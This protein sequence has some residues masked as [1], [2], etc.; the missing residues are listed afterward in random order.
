MSCPAF[1]IHETHG[2]DY[3]PPRQVAVELAK[4]YP[5]LIVG[6][7]HRIGR[8]PEASPQPIGLRVIPEVSPLE[9]PRRWGLRMLTDPANTR[10][11]RNAVRAEIGHKADLAV[12]FDRPVQHHRVGA[13]REVASAYYAHCDYTVDILGRSDPS[14]QADELAMLRKVDVAFAAS[15][16]LVERFSRH[17][18]RVV[19]L[20][21]GYISDLF[22]GDRTYNEPDALRG[23][24]RPRIL[25]CGYISG[26][27]DFVGLLATAL[28]KPEWTFVFLG[29]VSPDLPGELTD[30]GRPGDLFQ[31]LCD[32]PNVH[33]AGHVPLQ[34]VPPF[35]AACDVGLVPYC[36]SDFTMTSSPQK[37]F[38]YLAMGKPVVATAIPETTCVSDDIVLTHEASSYAPAIE[39]ALARAA[40]QDLIEKRKAAGRRN[41]M[42][43]RA[44][45]VETEL[46]GRK[47]V[48]CA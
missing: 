7:P 31:R 17:A 32:C 4:T 14:A 24:P 1:V 44:A 20:P 13:L 37:N 30:S 40:D 33:Y 43:V 28:A 27:V 3:M 19:H 46:L 16:L 8:R 26:R 12:L 22:D 45:T 34:S 5:T 21:C 39:Q 6:R 23:L 41:S 10:I 15:P 47:R 35:M 18:K 25:F 2:I 29:A 11:W 36:L 9:L 38:E 48:L 42:A